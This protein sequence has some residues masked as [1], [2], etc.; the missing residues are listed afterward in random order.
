M[1]FKGTLKIDLI[2]SELHDIKFIFMNLLHIPI[3]CLYDS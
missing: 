1:I 3:V 2:M